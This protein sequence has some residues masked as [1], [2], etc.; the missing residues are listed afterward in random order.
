M[1]NAG[2]MGIPIF[3][4][5][6]VNP[7]Y[8]HSSIPIFPTLSSS[9]S[10]TA[11]KIAAYNIRI[12]AHPWYAKLTL[13]YVYNLVHVKSLLLLWSITFLQYWEMIT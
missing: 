5:L 8:L 13:K 7:Y 11:D 1:G 3:P 4:K 12:I 6:L 9:A 2:N 10:A